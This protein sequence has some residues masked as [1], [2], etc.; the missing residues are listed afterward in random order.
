[1][2]PVVFAFSALPAVRGAAVVTVQLK[3]MP[4]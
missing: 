4:S 1:M 3:G 2:I